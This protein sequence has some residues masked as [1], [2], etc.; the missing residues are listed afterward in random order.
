M[1]NG[2]WKPL[3]LLPLIDYLEAAEAFPIP[4]G[5]LKKWAG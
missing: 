2:R 3:L 1:G 4:I 5:F